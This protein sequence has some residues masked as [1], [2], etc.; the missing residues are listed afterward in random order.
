MEEDV[1]EPDDPS[2]A[3]VEAG[4]GAVVLHEDKKYYPSAS[5]VR[6][7]HLVFS[8]SHSHAHSLSFCVVPSL[9]A[10]W[11]CRA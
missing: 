6:T 9:L 2:T 11:T 3:I 5:E 4:M 10:T 8:L 7:F 1:A